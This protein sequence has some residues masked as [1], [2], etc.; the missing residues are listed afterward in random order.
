MTS[1]TPQGLLIYTLGDPHSINVEALL[2]VVLPVAKRRPI[3]VI[4]SQWQVEYQARLLCIELPVFQVIQSLKDKG[5]RDAASGLFLLD[6]LPQTGN[7]APDTLSAEVCGELAVA[8]LRLVPKE[9]SSKMAVLSGPIDKHSA[10]LAG[11]KHPGQTEFFEELWQGKAIML[12]AGPKL[13]VALVT[14]HLPLSEIA[15]TI[16]SDLIQKKLAILTT[17]LRDLYS[18]PQPRIAVC[19]L[20]P[21]CG[22][23]G[24]FGTEEAGIIL[25]AIEAS[26]Q[27][28]PDTQFDGP[29]PADTIFYRAVQGDFDAVLAMYHDQGLGP[30]KTVHF[31][32]AV[33]VSLGL[34]YLRVS[35]DHGPAKDLY[36][37]GGG[38]VSWSSFKAALDLC[39][40]YLDRT[41]EV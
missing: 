4:G 26:R 7:S 21:H 10:N 14:N 5:L 41:S 30:L 40:N 20:N 37:I 3:V 31:D 36:G 6:P 33:N 1:K 8:A 11:F 12:L 28:F 13:R 32:D 27:M 38:K 23:H 15:K 19:G 17:G 9:H 25:P 22:D 24:L 18:I 29:L 16:S 34:K 2:R 39:E 35:P